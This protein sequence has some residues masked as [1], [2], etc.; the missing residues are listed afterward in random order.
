MLRAIANKELYV[1]PHIKIL[2]VEQ[3]ASGGDTTALRSVLEAD[4]E[5]ESLKKEERE[6]NALL[7]N[8]NTNTIQ[9]NKASNRLKEVYAL[10]EEMEAD[11]AESKASAILNGLGFSPAQQQAGTGTFSG[12]GECDLLLPELCSVS[13]IYSWQ[14]KSPII[15]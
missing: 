4:V 7:S 5:M 3:E 1:P 9:S 11:K 15:V 14:M 6:L 12:V 13:Q 2:H 10:L 8:P